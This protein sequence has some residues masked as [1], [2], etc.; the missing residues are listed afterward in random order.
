M[1]EKEGRIPMNDGAT[2]SLVLFTAS[3]SSDLSESRLTSS[4][5]VL[6][7]DGA[8]SPTSVRPIRVLGHGRAAEARLV[9]ATD[10][11]GDSVICVEKIFHPGLLTL[12]I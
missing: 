5:D 4:V 10:E 12:T 9:E 11:T 8:M 6:P 2:R 7:V 1:T 3:D